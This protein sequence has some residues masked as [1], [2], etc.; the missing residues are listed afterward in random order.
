MTRY[1]NEQDQVVPD[2]RS[3]IRSSFARSLL[4]LFTS[5]NIIILDR[6]SQ[7]S[8]PSSPPP[9]PPD[10]IWSGTHTHEIESFYA[11]RDGNGSA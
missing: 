8:S 9:A 1:D 5:T 6:H 10:G 4:Y 11:K 7:Y 2:P 3:P